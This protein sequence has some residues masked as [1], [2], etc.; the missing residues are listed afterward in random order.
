M[1]LVPYSVPPRAELH[2]HSRLSIR[3]SNDSGQAKVRLIKV[4]SLFVR[5]VVQLAHFVKNSIST[6]ETRVLN[7]DTQEILTYCLH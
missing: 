7:P 5:Y 1:E 3:R 4:R 6:K 2:H